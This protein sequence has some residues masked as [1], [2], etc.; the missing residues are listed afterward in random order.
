MRKERG[1]HRNCLSTPNLSRFPHKLHNIPALLNNLF[2]NFKILSHLKHHAQPLGNQ[3]KV[4]YKS[5][6]KCR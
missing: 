3:Q 5:I 2:R 4:K 1:L 6:F